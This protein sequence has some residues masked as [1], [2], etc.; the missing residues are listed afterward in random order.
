VGTKGVVELQ[1]GLKAGG[2]ERFPAGFVCDRLGDQTE[3]D[4]TEAVWVSGRA[5][6]VVTFEVEAVRELGDFIFGCF[7][8]HFFG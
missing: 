3:T 4:W 8:F 7:L 2:A 5:D 6:S 1:V